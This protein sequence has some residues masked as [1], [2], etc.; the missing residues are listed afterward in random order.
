VVSGTPAIAH[1]D[2]LKGA[3]VFET[4]GDLAKEVRQLRREVERLKKEKTP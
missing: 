1:R 4:L 2:W 3:T